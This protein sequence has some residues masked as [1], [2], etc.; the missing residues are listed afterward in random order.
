MR[1]VTLF[2]ITL[3]LLLSIASPILAQGGGE[4]A[5]PASAQIAGFRHE[6][7]GWNNCGPATLTIALSHFGWQ[8]DQYTAARWLKP[9]PEDKNVSAWQ[10]AEFVNRFTDVNALVRFSGDLT[11][12]HLL[13]AQNFPVIIEAGFE[14]AGYEWMGHYLLVMGYDD[15]SATILTQDSFLGPDKAYPQNELDRFWRHFNRV[16]IVLY[17][18]ERE[19]EL[20]ALLGEDADPQA[21]AAHALAVARQEAGADMSD[22]FAW[23]N[24]GTSYDL[25]GMYDQAAVAYDQARNSGDGL[26]WRMLWYQFGIFD[27]YYQVG[28]YDDVVALAQYNLATTPEN[29]HPIEE[30]YYYAGLAREALGEHERAILNL[31]QALL[32]NPNFEPAVQALAAITDGEGG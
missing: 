11:L 25:L 24:M 3:F 6:Y 1:P 28:R 32:I 26:P 15:P 29:E 21:N 8:D 13:I 19:T 20:L 4:A 23:F 27:A 9:D 22:P 5:L 7:Q 10:M 14:P 17:Q 31:Q 16:Y 18:P 30:T 12:L 2:S